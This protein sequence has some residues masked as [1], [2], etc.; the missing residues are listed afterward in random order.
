MFYSRGQGGVCGV[1]TG[2]FVVRVFHSGCVL[3]LRG[4]CVVG[5]EL[6]G[7]VIASIPDDLR[8][9]WGA[10]AALSSTGYD[11]LLLSRVYTMFANMESAAIALES[12]RRWLDLDFSEYAILQADSVMG[13]LALIRISGAGALELLELSLADDA[14]KQGVQACMTWV[15][16]WMKQGAGCV[17]ALCHACA[18]P[19]PEHTA[20]YM[21]QSGQVSV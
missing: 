21:Q 4:G 18:L 16:T 15:D 13:Y 17:G 8:A 10:F 11:Y 3:L 6:Q 19:V 7:W 1:S 14:C 9:Y 20:A 12:A 2:G 5:Q